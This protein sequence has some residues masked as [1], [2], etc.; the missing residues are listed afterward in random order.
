VEEIGKQVADAFIRRAQRQHMRGRPRDSKA[1]EFFAGAAAA[2][3]QGSPER[4]RLLMLATA[5]AIRGFGEVE[6]IG[7]LSPV[8]RP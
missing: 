7:V 1:V 2:H 8:L 5:I 4:E 6:R 3:P